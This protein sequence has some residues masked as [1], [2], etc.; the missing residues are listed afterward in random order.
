MLPYKN[1]LKMWQHNIWFQNQNEFNFEV[2]SS[3]EKLLSCHFIWTS[4]NLKHKSQHQFLGYPEVESSSN[5]KNVLPENHNLV[6]YRT[7]N[8]KSMHI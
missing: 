2:P 8:S 4:E 3:I 1:I 6:E 5:E 7:Q